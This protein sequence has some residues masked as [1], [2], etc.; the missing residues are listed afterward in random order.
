MWDV[1]V[2]AVVWS[3]AW[4][5]VD[6]VESAKWEWVDVQVRVPYEPV[7]LAAGAETSSKISSTDAR[8]TVLV[9]ILTQIIHC[10]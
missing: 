8:L 10:L 5:P 1:V 7:A 3:F 4:T 9:W 2:S 6:E